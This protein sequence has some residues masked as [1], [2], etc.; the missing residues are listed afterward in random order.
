MVDSFPSWLEGLQ[1]TRACPTVVNTAEAT[2]AAFTKES[3]LFAEK[4][5]V[6]KKTF[7]NM[8]NP[9]LCARQMAQ[10]WGQELGITEEESLRATL[11]GL[12]ALQTFLDDR[13]RQA[14]AIIDKLEKEDG[15]GIVLLA[16]PYH[17]DPGV[18]HEI[19]DEFQKLGYPVLTLDAL[20]IDEDILER[21]FGEE[22]RR[23]DF[24]SPLSIED[25]WKN[26]Y[27]EN[28]SRKV[29]GAKYTARHPNLVALELSSFK[30]GHDAPIYTVV[31]EIIEN[32]ATPYFCFKDVDENKPT[33]SIKIRVET[34]AY[35]LR[36]HRERLIIR[37][38][39]R[40]QIDNHL[41]G[42]AQRLGQPA[43]V[44]AATA[45][46]LRDRSREGAPAARLRP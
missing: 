22:V 32:S 31:E 3:D 41:A 27:S 24:A 15:I 36:R 11:E 40:A 4:G 19:T 37:R 28:T 33:G 14:R 26:S 45:Q 1:A 34:I 44:V 10:D 30:C 42:L 46:P 43:D 21:L 9:Q 7:I 38:R 39:K 17:N 2:H 6:Y 25:A 18:C 20:P 35:F 16:R 13:R 5:I 8:D 12:R 29:W 23:G